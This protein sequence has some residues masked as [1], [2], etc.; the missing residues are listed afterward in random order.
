MTAPARPAPSSP[1]PITGGSHVLAA[2]ADG[3]LVQLHWGPGSP[4]ATDPAS[5]RPPPC[6]RTSCRWRARSHCWSRVACAGGPPSLQIA[7]PGGVRS[8]ELKLVDDVVAAE[9]GAHRL[10]LVLADTHFPLQVVLHHRVREDSE[11]IERW[12]TLRHTAG[13]GEPLRI[14]RADSG[15]WLVPQL[16]DYRYSVVSGGYYAEGQLRRG[17]LADGEYPPHQPHQHHRAPRQ[18]PG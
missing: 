13:S 8:L 11:V 7:F 4:P 12:V 10:D 17:R 1:S 2:A 5:A 14:I 15:N 9:P 6:R 3:R 18:P 16:D